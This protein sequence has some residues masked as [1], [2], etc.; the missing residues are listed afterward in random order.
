[1][2]FALLLLLAVFCATLASLALLQALTP[3]GVWALEVGAA[4]LLT[5]A[6]VGLIVIPWERRL[7]L[8]ARRAVQA[9][10]SSND[11][12]WVLDG[13]GRF[14]EVNDAYCRMVDLPREQVMRMKIADFEAVA[15]Q[16]R[17]R[18]QIQRILKA[19]HERF[20][21]RHRRRDGQWIDLEITVT[22]VDHGLLVAF[23]RDVSQRKAADERINRLAFYDAL[24]GLPNR[25]LLRDR[26]D[27]AVLTSGRH[28][29]SGALLFLDL[30]NFK[31][32]NDTRGH[33][34]GDELLV[35]VAQRLSQCV[36]S[37]DTVARQGGDEFVVVLE[38][39]SGDLQVA[40][41]A[42]RHVAEKC[43]AAL[44]QV[45]V[46]SCGEFHVSGSF[47][48][49]VFQ[50]RGVTTGELEQRAD[51]AMY[52]AKLSGRNR[53]VF[54]EP[55]MLESLA[56]R[57]GLEADLRD[58]LPL[59]A[60]VPFFQAQV[61]VLG[62]IIGAEVLLRW[63]HP[64]R[65][66]VSPM[67]FIPLAEETGLIMPLGAWVIEGA[68]T[69]LARWRDE[70]A[71]QHLTLSVNVSP[72]QFVQPGFVEH[73]RGLVEAGHFNPTQLHLELTEG[74]VIRNLDEVIG[75]MHMVRSLGIALS[76]D[77]FGTGQSSLGNLRRL[78][79][80]CLK[81][82]KSFVEVLPGGPGEAAIASS[83]VMMAGALG[84]DVIAEGVETEAQ[85]DALQALGCLKYQ[86]YLFGRPV[87]LDAFEA[88]L[89]DQAPGALAA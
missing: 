34:L 35:Q 22:A 55:S 69:Q 61:D 68:C 74:L 13:E 39:L 77:D 41:H 53:I 48:A 25:R 75:R 16:D 64:H 5:T 8:G 88:S 37:T 19:G 58:A 38:A 60:I 59:G 76:M 80:Q 31:L 56:R 32:L 54:F 26:I 83:I 84:L 46:L 17:I 11:G 1:M 51:T 57:T 14:V 87:P 47:G 52:Q 67:E 49:V 7:R 30:D 40:E 86:G 21:T 2:R 66:W 81:I 15:T 79:I 3:E 82:D 62:R 42:A 10:D 89:R 45:F 9:I 33:A 78:P 73:L 50:G 18:A 71:A 27:R 65:G 23:L 4:A 43:R 63:R 28:G 24:T 70:P 6:L 20:E 44:E 72:L 85:R 29:H 36:R 12:Y